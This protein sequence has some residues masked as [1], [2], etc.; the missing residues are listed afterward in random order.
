MPL[1][2]GRRAGVPPDPGCGPQDEPA[3]FSLYDWAPWR[4]CLPGAQEDYET[5]TGE[6]GPGNRGRGDETGSKGLG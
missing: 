4:R 1:G 3:V 2:E 6:V 5:E